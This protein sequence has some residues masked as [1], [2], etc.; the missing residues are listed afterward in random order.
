[1]AYIVTT[2]YENQI[3]HG[4]YETQE[5]AYIRA[6]K[7]FMNVWKYRLPKKH[8]ENHDTLANIIQTLQNS[9][10][11]ELFKDKHRF[12]IESPK[13]N[14]NYYVCEIYKDKLYLVH[15]YR[16]NPYA[17]SARKL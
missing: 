6:I 15:D 8:V 7:L 11:Q 14:P 5:E 13:D 4:L 16:Y 10:I 9:G 12:I 1:M 17:I 2:H 3:D